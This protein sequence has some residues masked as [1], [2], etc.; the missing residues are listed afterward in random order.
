MFL[1]TTV[2]IFAQERNDTLNTR[3]LD[4]VTITGNRQSDLTRLP[5][6]EG[7]RIWSGKKKQVTGAKNLDANIAE[8]TAPQTLPRSLVCSSMIWTAP[9]IKLISPFAVWI[10]N[11][12]IAGSIDNFWV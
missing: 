4:E 10:E 5:P 8:K 12:S 11:R 6:I 3:T 2:P 7:T 1:I 9:G